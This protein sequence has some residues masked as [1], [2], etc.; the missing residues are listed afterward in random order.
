MTTRVG[1]GLQV[2]HDHGSAYMSDDIQRELKF[3]GMELASVHPRAREPEGNG[4]TA[5]P[6]GSSASRRRSS[7]ASGRSRGSRNCVRPSWSSSRR[8][9]TAGSSRATDTARHAK[10]PSSLPSPC[11]G[12]MIKAAQV[13]TQTRGATQQSQIEFSRSYHLVEGGNWNDLTNSTY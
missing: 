3:F 8:T 13:S 7:S 6:S 11:G 4:A 12:R 5:A 2:R 10:W 1:D 9:T